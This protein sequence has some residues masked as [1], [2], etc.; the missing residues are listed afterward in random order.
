MCTTQLAVA[1]LLLIT[2]PHHTGFRLKRLLQT[3]AMEQEGLARKL[4]F[5][6]LVTADGIPLLAPPSSTTAAA[7][8]R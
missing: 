3:L 2:T 7:P 1:S 4:T 6:A 5:P 8:I